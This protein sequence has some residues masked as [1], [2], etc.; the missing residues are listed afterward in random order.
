MARTVSLLEMREDVVEQ[1]DL[2]TPSASTFITTSRLNRWIAQSTRRFIGMLL[3][4]LGDRYFEAPHDFDTEVGTAQYDLPDDFYQLFS[5]AVLWDGNMMPIHP[6]T[7]DEL[8]YGEGDYVRHDTVPGYR[9]LGS[10]IEMVPVPERVYSVRLRYAPTKIAFNDIGVPIA[11]L[12]DDSHYIDGING[13][14]EWIV[15]DTCVKAKAKSD[16]DPSLFMAMKAEIEADIK[17]YASKRDRG[18]KRIREVYNGSR[19]R[20][21]RRFPWP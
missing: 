18:P 11:D 1:C 9:V 6:A 21:R 13:W 16:E 19:D 14:E 10:K 8:G 4:C 3:S 2:P 17:A 5:V 20:R 15:Q 7:A 12:T